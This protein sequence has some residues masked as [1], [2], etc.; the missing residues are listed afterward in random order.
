M[1]NATIKNGDTFGNWRVIGLEENAKQYNYN[2]VCEC[3]SCGFRK[4][5]RKDK[6]LGKQPR[7]KGCLP[8]KPYKPRSWRNKELDKKILQMLSNEIGA[9]EISRLLGVTRDK[10]RY[11]QDINKEQLNIIKR[12]EEEILKSK[13]EEKLHCE[14]KQQISQETDLSIYVIDKIFKKYNLVLHGTGICINCGKKYDTTRTIGRTR[15]YCSE[16]CREWHKIKQS[17]TIC[18]VCGRFIIGTGKDVCSEQCKKRRRRK[19]VICGTYFY[20]FH[21]SKFCSDKCR[22]E[23]K[24]KHDKKY[25]NKMIKRKCVLCGT[26]FECKKSSPRT[27]CSIYCKNATV[28]NKVNETLLELFGTIDKAKI[29]KKVK[30]CLD[31]KNRCSNRR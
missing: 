2:Y 25:R 10:V 4:V 9:T 24:R 8:S 29:R 27:F 13:I 21:T 6:L 15:K 16:Q 11:V 5:I 12:K 31:E 23:S 22:T 26:E 28:L 1:A 18:R 7:C 19:C 17:V 30:E 3:V 20:G 14:T